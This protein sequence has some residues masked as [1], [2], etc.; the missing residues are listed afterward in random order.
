MDNEKMK[1]LVGTGIVAAG[2]TAVGAVSHAVT[3]ELVKIAVDRD[4]THKIP[5]HA[6]AQFKGSPDNASFTQ[7]VKEAEEKLERRNHVTVEIAAADGERLV[8]HWFA[9]E[10]AKRIVI[11]MHGWRASWSRNFGLIA[12]FLHD[13]GCSVLYV[14]QRG[15]GNSG[16][17]Y[18]G[19][20]VLE[21]LDCLDWIDWVDDT[22][23]SEVPI[24]L[25]GVSMGAA[26]VLM[27]TGLDLPLNVHGIIADCGYTSPHEICKHI[28]EN[29]LHISYGHRGDVADEICRKKNR[30][31]I[32]VCSAVDALRKNEVPVL[33]I[34]GA[35]DHF[36]PV[37]MT[38]ENYEACNAPK[39]LLIV[40]GADHA[41]SYYVDRQRYESYVM[42]FWRKYD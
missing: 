41:M 34:H 15:Q 32:K 12:D 10:N 38:Y 30:V 31:G 7:A 35:N 37:E 4:D 14:E 19:L 18:M 13:N 16:G 2:I 24:Y 36:V 21:R 42:D 11:A 3:K 39:E 8:G 29:N 26:A 1:K 9:C 25:M 6:K 22:A 5:A 27:A 28:V 40:P 23:G 33:F 20:G 17:D